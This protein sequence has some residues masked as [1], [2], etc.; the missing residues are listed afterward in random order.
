MILKG[1]PNRYST[2]EAQELQELSRQLQDSNPKARQTRFAVRRRR[3]IFF[4]VY[5]EYFRTGNRHPR[6]LIE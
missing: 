1:I 3:S 4:I 2:N 5:G 6:A